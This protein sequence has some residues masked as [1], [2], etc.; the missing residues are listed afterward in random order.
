MSKK[1]GIQLLFLLLSVLFLGCKH[2]QKTTI[3]QPSANLNN[4]GPSKPEVAELVKKYPKENLVLI[5]T[6][7]GNMVARLFNETPAHRDNF[8]KLVEKN[9]Y[10]SLLFHRV[11]SNFMIQGGDPDSKK[12]KAGQKLGDGDIGY[13][14]PAEFKPENLFHKK[15]MLCAARE[16]DDIN[17]KK[18]SSACQFYIVQG[19]KFDDAGLKLV[20]YRVNRDLR[21]RLRNELLEADR[22]QPLKEEQARLKKE[23]KKDSLLL[24]EKIDSLIAPYYEK[25]PHYVFSEAQK[26]VYKTIGGT[27]HLDGSYTV[28]GEVVWGL[29]VVDRIAAEETDPNDR[30]IQD[31]R[32]HMKMLKK[33]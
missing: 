12:A 22:N 24:V 30:P 33:Y 31:I 7:M 27:P 23:G 20:E 3:S 28:Y 16:S 2:T 32:M 11:I 26:T 5:E 9:Y 19:K 10:D 13:T 18:A 15:G 6:S 1:N 14:V 17:P 29:D 25:S 8:S 4:N 21:T